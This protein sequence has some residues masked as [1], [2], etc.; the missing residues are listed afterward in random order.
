LVFGRQQLN[1]DSA[2]VAWIKAVGPRLTNAGTVIVMPDAH[3]LSLDRFAT[4]GFS[5]VELHF[6]ADWVESDG[7]PVGTHTSTKPKKS[8]LWRKPKRASA[9]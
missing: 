4:V 1:E 2:S 7:F 6:L 3:H 5:A 8:P 9:N